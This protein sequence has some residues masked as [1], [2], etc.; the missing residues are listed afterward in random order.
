MD[1][2]K[3]LK[4]HTFVVCA[5]KESQFLEECIKSLENQT[6]KSN[7]IMVTSTPNDYIKKVAKKNN[8][9]LY[10]NGGEKGIGQD[11]NFG[12]SK[13]LTKYVTV[14]HQD[15]IYNSNYLEEIAKGIN[16]DKEFIIAF[17]DYREIKNGKIIPLTKNLKIKKIL[18]SRL[19]KNGNSKRA[20][21]FA[22]KFGS[23]IC[24]PCVTINT[25][26]TGK[27]PYITNFKCDLDW[28]TWYEFS[29]T[30][31][32]FLYIDKELMCHRIHE[33]SETS[34]LIENNVRLQEDYEMLKKFWP[35]PIARIIMIFYKEAI[36]TNNS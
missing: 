36:K 24:C 33:D 30:D 32:D 18:L 26:I 23:A 29:K 34:N 21:K 17:G 35:K 7:I 31:Y 10:I 5:Y 1:L 19:M 6:V 14:A 8:I 3:E 27:K 16:K 12:V 28:E 20:K 4:N 25:D 22:L 13:T 11:W 15:D 2:M 9:E